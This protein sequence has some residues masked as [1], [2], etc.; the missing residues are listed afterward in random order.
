VVSAVVSPAQAGASE[1]LSD[2][3]FAGRF[4]RSAADHQAA[5]PVLRIAHAGL[6]APEAG[7]LDAEGLGDLGVARWHPL[8]GAEE[9]EEDVNIVCGLLGEGVQEIALTT[10]RSKAHLRP[11]VAGGSG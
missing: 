10:S 11:V 3:Y 1:A 5:T 8:Q 4:G 6:V 2:D 7:A 9:L